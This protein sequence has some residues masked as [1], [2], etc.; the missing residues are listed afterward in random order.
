MKTVRYPIKSSGHSVADAGRC[1]ACREPRRLHNAGGNV[2]ADSDCTVPWGD[3][4]APTAPAPAEAAPV[5][6]A[7]PGPAPA[8]EP[9][10]TPR[11]PDP[12]PAGNRALEPAAVGGDDADEEVAAIDVGATAAA[13]TLDDLTALVAQV[14]D[15][16]YFYAVRWYCPSCVAW[17]LKP[18]AC[19]HCAAALQ[20]VYLATIPRSLT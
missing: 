20:P 12:R 6:A 3:P 17:P 16:A 14:L 1:P 10:E 11:R 8:D 9:V 19:E 15:H 4:D 18:G 13:T 7:P 5:A 2:R